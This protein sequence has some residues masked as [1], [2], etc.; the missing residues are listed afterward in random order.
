MYWLRQMWADLVRPDKPYTIRSWSPKGYHLYFAKLC[1]LCKTFGEFQAVTP[2]EAPYIDPVWAY[3][4]LLFSI[5][6]WGKYRLASKK[7]SSVF[8]TSI[9]RSCLVV[10]GAK[11]RYQG[12]WRDLWSCLQTRERC[13]GNYPYEKKK[14]LHDPLQT[15]VI[16]IGR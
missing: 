8:Q 4:P 5:F 11:W 9:F 2:V 7:I 14:C 3:D 13:W 16:S 10:F 1:A 12:G 15:T 6:A